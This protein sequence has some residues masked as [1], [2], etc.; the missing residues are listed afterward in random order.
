MK[1]VT[2][3]PL[4]LSLAV[5]QPACT[6]FEDESFSFERKDQ[7]VNVTDGNTT[8]RVAVITGDIVRVDYLKGNVKDFQRDTSWFVT[9]QPVNARFRIRQTEQ[10]LLIHTNRLVV[11]VSKEPFAAHFLDTDGNLLLTSTRDAQFDSTTTRAWFEAA[12]DD[13]FYGMGQKSI[14]VNRRGYSFRSYN[15]HIGGYTRPYSTMQVNI[16]YV[17]SPRGWGVLFDNPWTGYFDM[18]KSNPDEWS[19]RT[20]GGEYSFYVVH[21]NT[22]Q[23]LLR[24]YYDLTGYFPMFPKWTLGLLQSKCAYENDTQVYRIVSSFRE[25]DLPLDAIILD[26]YWFGG[27]K[28]GYPNNLGNFTWLDDN[29]PD[30]RHYLDT[31]H[32]L[33]IKTILINEPYINL[34]SENYRFLAE[35]GWL[36]SR[37]DQSDPYVFSPFWAGDASLLDITHPDAQDWLWS[38]LKKNVSEGVDGLWIDLTEPEHP[39]PD[40]R[41]HMG[42]AKKVHNLYSH[43]FAKTIWEGYRSD[44]PD[45]RVFNLTRSATAGTQRYGA[46]VWSGDASKTWNALKLQVPMLIGTAISGMPHFASDIGG[47]TNAHDRRDGMTIFTNFNGQGVL[48]TPEMYTRWFQFGTFSPLLRPHSGEEQYCEPFAFDEQTEQITSRYLEYRY[49]LV[50]FLYS[51]MYKTAM[52]GE[53][54]IR[55]MFFMFDQEEAYGKDYQYMFGKEMLVAPVLD[56]GAREVEVWLPE[57]EN[58]RGWIDLHSGKKFE[59]GQTLEVSAP[60]DEIPVFVKQPSLFPLG[61]VKPH[62]GASPDDTLTVMVYPG[63]NAIFD[64]YEDDGTSND[65][66]KGKF[67]VTS[68]RTTSNGNDLKIRINAANGQFEQMLKKRYWIIKVHLLKDFEKLLL[69]NKEVTT[70]HYSYN[71]KT[72]ILTFGIW[73]PVKET[74]KLTLTNP[75]IQ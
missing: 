59:G 5:F 73:H 47:F 26:A 50:P 31:L 4:L 67:A 45:K 3:L 7:V 60:L 65:Y 20:D 51:Y 75:S 23:G 72:Q 74:L 15:Q 21:R 66:R 16:P 62:I 48:T 64:L 61:K 12:S 38:M 2:L 29:F 63:G 56:E 40:G 8:I 41:F 43:L 1:P 39:V 49:R 36:V 70:D 25:K 44:F 19:Y 27:Y 55:P 18:A 34:E 11:E 54:L 32:S 24:G 52:T 22:P 35:N 30:H 57:L 10:E 69:N 42:P 46:M 17:Y 58:N 37:N 33:G 53:A 13:R 28:E 14:D 71:E 68:L 9:K 6:S